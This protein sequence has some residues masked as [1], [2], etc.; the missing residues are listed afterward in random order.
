MRFAKH[1]ATLFVDPEVS[2][3]IEHLRRQWDP[4]MARQI[5]AHV[6]LVYPWEAPDPELISDWMRAAVQTQPPFRLRLGPL[7]RH[8]SPEGVGCGYAVSDIDEGHHRLRSRIT[9]PAFM[10]GDVDPHVTVVH[11]RT[12]SHGDAAWNALQAQPLEVDFWVR[13]VAITAWDG[14]A[15]PTLERIPLAG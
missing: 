5:A 10:P 13:D 11:P 6:T 4:D 2:E 8:V 7:E 12:S 15:W 14:T 3:P 1:H 9:S